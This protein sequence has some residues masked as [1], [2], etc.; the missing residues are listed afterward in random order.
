MIHLM[1]ATMERD[2]ICQCCYCCCY[3]YYYYYYYITLSY[4]YDYYYYYYYYYDE[5][6]RWCEKDEL[7]QYFNEHGHFPGPVIDEPYCR[8]SMNLP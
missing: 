8:P 2:N 6:F 4:D 5:Y 1:D 7:I 3:Y